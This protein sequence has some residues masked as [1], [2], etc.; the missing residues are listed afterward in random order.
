MK[1]ELTGYA[2]SLWAT[3]LVALATA[4]AAWNK[5]KGVP[6]VGHFA[7]AMTCVAF[8]CLMSGAGAATVGLQAKL[9]F[10]KV[11]YLGICGV[12]PLFLQFSRAY[13]GRDSFPGRLHGVLLWALPAATVVLVFSNEWHHLVW[14]GYAVIAFPV[15]NAIIYRHGTWYW[16]WVTWCG[17][18]TSLGVVGLVSS[19]HQGSKIYLRQTVVFVT[20]AAL[21]WVGEA[22]YIWRG[23]PFPGLDLSSIGFAAMGVLVLL[24]MSRFMLFDIVPVART[25][26]V[27]KV[28]EGIIVLDSK[29]RIVEINPAAQRMLGADSAA[30]GTHGNNVFAALRHLLPPTAP[31]CEEYRT[32]V[33]LPGSS[34]EYLDV[35]VTSLRAG[36][37]ECA[38]SMIV[39]RDVSARRRLE[40]QNKRLIVDLQAA[41]ADVKTMR[42]LLPICSSCKRI[43][44]D[45]GR[46][47]NI[48]EYVQGHSEARFSHGLCDDCLARMH[49]DLTVNNPSNESRG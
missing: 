36:R 34:Q 16:V 21:P 41:L 12:G 4:D 31:G 15:A 7:A 14:T 27:D 43:R 6:G 46:W 17:I 24:G 48:E 23:N 1:F 5:R 20:G 8:W 9:I 11:G 49:P 10:S 42:G 47:R 26:I 25:F 35:V 22:L 28:S 39:L 29:N 33:A 40:E 18:V 45:G 2:V 13:S 19:A 3:A 30:I 32:D 44:D 38:G 37:G